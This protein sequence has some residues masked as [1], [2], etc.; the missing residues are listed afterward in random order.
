MKIRIK[1]L[2]S[3]IYYEGEGDTLFNLEANIAF[4]DITEGVLV[5][6]TEGT[7]PVNEE[8]GDVWLNEEPKPK[9]RK[10]KVTA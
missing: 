5:A 1:D 3:H 7:Y 4:I 2:D 9:K 6:T 10:G 8:D